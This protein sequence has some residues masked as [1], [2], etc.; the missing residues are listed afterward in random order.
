M[1]ILLKFVQVLYTLEVVMKKKVVLFFM[2]DFLDDLIVSLALLW[3]QVG[4]ETNKV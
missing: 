2:L 3:I 4:G 1:T